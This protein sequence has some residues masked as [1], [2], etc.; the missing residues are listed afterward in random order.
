MRLRIL[1]A[2]VAAAIAFMLLAPTMARA[3]IVTFKDG[4]ELHGIIKRVAA[5]QVTL[6]LG[7]GEE[8]VFDILDVNNMEFTTP[9]VVA[10][11]RVPMEHFLKDIEAQEIVRG[12]QE[13]EK[14]AADIRLRLTQIQ[15]YWEAKQ[16][17]TS[18][19]VGGWEAAREVF[20]QPVDRYQELLSDL[21]FHVLA[22][23]DEYNALMKQADRV[24]VGVKG[25]FN[26]GSSLV[27]KE[28]EKLPLRKYVPAPWYDTIYYN[29]YDHGYEDAYL[30]FATPY[31]TTPSN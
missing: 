30:K 23:V 7:L 18:D 25:P 28:L 22:K 29:G 4:T 20:R 6:D 5:G 12:I 31:P 9:H 11:P 16:P 21:Y 10:S 24:Y 27:P 2:A 17:I 13:I 8:M 1:T 3:D 19:E 15:N 14:A 26:V